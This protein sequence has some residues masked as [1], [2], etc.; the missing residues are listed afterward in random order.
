VANASSESVKF[1]RTIL[2][3]LLAAFWLPASSHVVLERFGVIHVVHHDHS[4]HAEPHDAG[5]SHEHHDAGHAA[6]DGQVV[7]ST[8]FF[9]LP[10][11]S[12]A[13][14]PCFV[15]CLVADLDRQA[16]LGRSF[17]LGP[18]ETAPPELSH[19]WQFSSRAALPV[20]APSF[21]S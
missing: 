3:L 20:R 21:V 7:A 4:H 15:F 5:G 9:K 2:A 18:P 8:T 13:L 16:G 6:A 1:A 19:R 11:P 12:A 17:S 14:V 10:T